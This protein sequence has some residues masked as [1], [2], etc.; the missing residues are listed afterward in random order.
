MNLEKQ[1]K[2]KTMRYYVNVNIVRCFF[3]S[4]VDS[5]LRTVQNIHIVTC[6]WPAMTAYCQHKKIEWINASNQAELKS[7]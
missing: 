5:Q 3:F 4:G 6:M 1:E 7:F 2:T